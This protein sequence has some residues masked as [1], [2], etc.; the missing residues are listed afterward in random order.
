MWIMSMFEVGSEKTMGDSLDQ[1]GCSVATVAI[2]DYKIV[3]AQ[4]MSAHQTRNQLHFGSAL[5]IPVVAKM[6]SSVPE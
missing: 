3:D 4:V 6:A 1:E 5:R 2:S